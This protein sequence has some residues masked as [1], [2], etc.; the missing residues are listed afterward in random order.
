[1]TSRGDSNRLIGSHPNSP[2]GQVALR[3]SSCPRVWR[4]PTFYWC[5]SSSGT[6]PRATGASGIAANSK[7]VRKYEQNTHE[8]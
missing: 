2:R 7:E 3:A 1:M 8:G 5:G 6:M 4:W